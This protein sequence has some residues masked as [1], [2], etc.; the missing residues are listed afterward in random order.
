MTIQCRVSIADNKSNP[1]TFNEQLEG[2]KDKH[3][4]NGTVNNQIF[5]H[6]GVAG[7]E[8]LLLDSDPNDIDVTVIYDPD[9]DCEGDSD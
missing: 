4:A 7:D 2:L 8:D 3:V 9:R 6:L 5:E 1:A